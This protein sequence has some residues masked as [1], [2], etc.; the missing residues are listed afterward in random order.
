MTCLALQINHFPGNGVFTSKVE[1]ARTM[2]SDFHPASFRLPQ[3][4]DSFKDVVR[5]KLTKC[6][7]VH[8]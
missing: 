1:L 4:A 6:C 5:V 2:S 8:V 7:T 3:E